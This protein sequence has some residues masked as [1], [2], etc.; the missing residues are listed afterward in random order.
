M[1]FKTTINQQNFILHISGALFWESKNTLL[2]ADIHL[3]KVTHFRKN[4]F[5]IPNETLH[6]N[7]LKLKEVVEF[8]QPAQIIFLRRFI[9]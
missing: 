9:S 3:G 2:I 1:T 6:Q 7:F 4:G 5:A 8:F